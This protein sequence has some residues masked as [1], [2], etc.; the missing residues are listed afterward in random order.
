MVREL[1]GLELE[2]IQ[3]LINILCKKV[4]SNTEVAMCPAL[5]KVFSLLSF[6]SLYKNPLYLST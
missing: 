3:F 2:V 5:P 4:W 6:L 1:V